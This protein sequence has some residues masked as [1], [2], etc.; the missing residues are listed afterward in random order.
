MDLPLNQSESH[1]M[2]KHY[3]LN[4]TLLVGIIYSYIFLWPVHCF[5][6]YF[7]QLSHSI[8]MFNL[9]KKIIFI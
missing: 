9:M 5:H 7:S 6:I 2:R 1:F 4:Y 8:E 3:M